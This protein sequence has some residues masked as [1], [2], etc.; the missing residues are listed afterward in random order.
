MVT[1]HGTCANKATRPIQAAAHLLR[2]HEDALPAGR[3]SLGIAQAL[4][5]GSGWL[6][7][8][9]VFS[10]PCSGFVKAPLPRSLPG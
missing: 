10:K 2:A 6:G 9:G 3:A 8:C 4:P 7:E 1:L 5:R